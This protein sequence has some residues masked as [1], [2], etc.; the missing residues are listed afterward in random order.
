M[1]TRDTPETFS[2]R[3][4]QIMETIFRAGKATAAEVQAAI[5]DGPGYSAIRALLR[6]LEEKGHLRHEDDGGRYV[7]FPVASRDK[8]RKSA[9]RRLA[10]TFF[11]GSAVLA[12]SIALGAATGSA[13][14]APIC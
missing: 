8:A 9:M 7:Y 14:F 12:A 2:R 3:E 5:A 6:I 4:R 1:A 11:A 10:D 13:G